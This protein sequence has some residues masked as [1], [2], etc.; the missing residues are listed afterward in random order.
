MSGRNGDAR[1]IWTAP[2]T[3]NAAALVSLIGALVAEGVW[4]GL[5]ALVLL[6]ALAYAVTLGLRS[7]PRGKP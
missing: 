5:A 4:D 1:R 6:G 2:V 7:A 3:I